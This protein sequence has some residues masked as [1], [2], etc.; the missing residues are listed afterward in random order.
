[1]EAC[2]WV[3]AAPPP[4]L[5]CARGNPRSILLDRPAA[6]LRRRPLLEDDVLAAGGFV[7]LGDGGLAG[8]V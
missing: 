1:L 8:L 3:G 4:T 5:F 7:A 2:S 6:A